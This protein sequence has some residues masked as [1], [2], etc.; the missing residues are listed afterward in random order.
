LGALAV[1]MAAM[2]LG[3]GRTA[4]DDVIDHAVGVVC[5]RKRGDRVSAGDTLA[6]IHARD[7]AA[8][9]SAATEVKAAYELTDEE[10]RAG[11]IILDTLV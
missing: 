7:E 4:K 6:E 1:G 11:G 2:H 8:V 9:Q 10:P 5:L 3:A